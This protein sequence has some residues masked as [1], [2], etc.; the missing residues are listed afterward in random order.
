MGKR[1]DKLN[2]FVK[3]GK[4]TGYTPITKR[5]YKGGKATGKVISFNE[6]VEEFKDQVS[7]D[8][9]E[10]RNYSELGSCEH[11][12]ITEDVPDY[13]L[14]GGKICI[15]DQMHKSFD[16]DFSPQ[17]EYDDY[18]EGY[19]Q[20]LLDEEENDMGKKK[21][22]KKKTAK[23]KVTKKKATKKKAVS[24]KKV[25]KKKTS[26]KK[27]VSK[28]KSPAKKKIAKK[29]TSKKKA[30]TKKKT[31]ATKK[32]TKS[33]GSVELLKQELEEANGEIGILHDR[34]NVLERK[35][36]SNSQKIKTIEN[37]FEEFL[38]KEKQET[39]EEQLEE[40]DEDDI[41]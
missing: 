37:D 40:D 35:V 9:S 30:V 39:Y 4:E 22:S 19:Y 33:K 36:A 34:V 5:T 17:D 27:A 11:D 18:Q 7:A 26:K 15:N 41:F 24:K 21:V 16:K 6:T 23:K 14:M 31:A 2:D 10:N 38:A 1:Y 8:C 20:S 28:K 3:Q 32:Q 25:T 29:K 12:T 13:C